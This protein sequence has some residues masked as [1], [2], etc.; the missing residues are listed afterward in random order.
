[1]RRGITVLPVAVTS[2]SAHSAS[3]FLK[4]RAE[5]KGADVLP[6]SSTVDRRTAIEWESNKKS[7]LCVCPATVDERNAN[8]DGQP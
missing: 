7:R 8:A 5:G 2:R 4:Q 1:M 3:A 6:V